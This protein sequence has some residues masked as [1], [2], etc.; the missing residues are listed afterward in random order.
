MSASLHASAVAWQDQAVLITGKSGSGKSTLALGL[1]AY[2]CDLVA[3]DR[4]LLLAENGQLFAR[5]PET[6]TGLI[7]ARGIGVLNA[8]PVMRARV[9]LV[10]DLDRVETQR[11]PPRRSITL[12]NCELPL[13]YRVDGPHWVPAILQ[14]LKSGWSDR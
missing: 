10:V 11:L 9:C 14:L 5:A 8:H 12:E 4:A 1:M 3:D 2:G 7:E 13:I 6:I